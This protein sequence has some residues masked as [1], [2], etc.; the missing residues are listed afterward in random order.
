M[1]IR[2]WLGAFLIDEDWPIRRVYRQFGASR[3]LGS[4][5]AIVLR[6]NILS[7]F[8]PRSEELHLR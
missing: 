4:V 6:D 7:Y 3:N 8:R 1:I 5:L 2:R